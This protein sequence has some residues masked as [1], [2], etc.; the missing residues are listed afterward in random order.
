MVIRALDHVPHCYTYEDGLRIAE[1]LAISLHK[2]EDVILSFEGVNGVPS[3]FVNGAFI[4]L[5]TE[6][7]VD[8][9]RRHVQV[10]CST[11][12]IN[13]LIKSRVSAEASRSMLAL[14]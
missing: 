6:F 9:V 14:V 10:V 11:R 5:I 3:S 13:D 12:Q 4:S 2:H 1:L 7:S 8:D